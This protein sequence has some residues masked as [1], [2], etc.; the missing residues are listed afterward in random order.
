MSAIPP[1]KARRLSAESLSLRSEPRLAGGNQFPPRAPLRSPRGLWRPT[2]GTDEAFDG[3]RRHLCQVWKRSVG[4]WERKAAHVLRN[5][6]SAARAAS[7]AGTS[8]PRVPPSA[9]RG[10]SGGLH[11]ER[12]K[13]LTVNADTSVRCGSGPSAVGK[14]RPRMF[15]GTCVALRARPR[16]REPVPP[17]APL[18]S[19]R[20][21]WRPTWGT[22]GTAF[23]SWSEPRRC[24]LA[25]C[26]LS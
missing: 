1:S 24:Q 7:R 15:C 13:P 20:G 8:S 6:R 5:M 14:E 4:R 26:D 21:L 3:K 22:D 9:L 16:G 18:R 17:R 25:Y 23:A 10:G 12:T 11:G 2:W 19:P